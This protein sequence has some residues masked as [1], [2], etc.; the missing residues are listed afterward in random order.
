MG[1]SLGFLQ[2]QLQGMLL[3]LPGP[4]SNSDPNHR[5]ENCCYLTGSGYV[6]G[7]DLVVPGH[8]Q[9][10]LTLTGD[11]LSD[12]AVH[13]SRRSPG[14]PSVSSTVSPPLDPDVC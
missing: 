1:F 9:T 7:M 14:S 4:G 13:D 3:L 8:F 2:L 11:G 10:L 6:P 12:C 5:N